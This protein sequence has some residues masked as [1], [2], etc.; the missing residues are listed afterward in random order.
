[1]LRIRIRIRIF[2]IV[3]ADPDSDPIKLDRIRNTGFAERPP[4]IGK[5]GG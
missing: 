2:D 5:E 4:K 3:S 1:M